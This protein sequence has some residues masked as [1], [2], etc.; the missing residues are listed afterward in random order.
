M[1][2]LSRQLPDERSLEAHPLRCPAQLLEGVAQG[3]L[4]DA[5]LGGVGDQLGGQLRAVLERFDEEQRGFGSARGR[6]GLRSGEDFTRRAMIGIRPIG[7]PALRWRA[8]FRASA[9]PACSRSRPNPG[10]C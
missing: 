5:R 1:Q 4:G 3:P 7:R 9:G 6:L 8:N 2:R 10:R